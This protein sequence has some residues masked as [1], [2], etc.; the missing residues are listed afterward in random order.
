M[1]SEESVCFD[2]GFDS[3][4]EMQIQMRC[5]SDDGDICLSI[6]NV[7]AETYSGFLKPSKLEKC[8]LIFSL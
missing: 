2:M 6:I 3:L 1:F 8:G 4:H 7:D 5:L